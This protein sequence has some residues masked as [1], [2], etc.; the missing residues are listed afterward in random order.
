MKPLDFLKLA[1]KKYTVIGALAPTSKYIHRKILQGVKP[2]YRY[3]VEY[4]AGD[5]AV[6]KAILKV[7]PAEGRVVAIEIE[8]GF[9]PAL[10]GIG[11]PRLTIVHGNAVAVVETLDALGLPRID[12]VVSGIPFSFM[13]AHERRSIVSNT[14]AALA[15]GGR[16]LVY[17]HF[18][19]AYLSLKKF[20][21][22]VRLSFEPRNESPCFIMIAEK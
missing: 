6:T 15:S 1:L 20:F 22:S 21:K 12:L 16:F 13:K 2:G 3:V 10:K 14:Y 11:D 9:I 8:D 19:F 18:P 5:G 17:Q 4:G 7:L